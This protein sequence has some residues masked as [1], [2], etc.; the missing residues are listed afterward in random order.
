[1]S[2]PGVF[3]LRAEGDRPGGEVVDVA[4][5]LAVRQRWSYRVPEALR[6]VAVP[7]ARVAVPFRGRPMAGVVL[8][9]G[10]PPPGMKLASVLGALDELPIFDPPLLAFL[11]EAADYY[12]H[13]LG[14]VLR[15]AAPPLPTDALRTLR[16]GGLLGDHRVKGAKARTRLA[17]YVRRSEAATD[18]ALAELR[19]GPHQQTLLAAL[20]DAGELAVET[21][22][23]AVKGAIASLRKRGLVTVTEREVSLDRFFSG[24]VERDEDRVP[25]AEQATAIGAITGALEAGGRKSFLL[26]GVTG[27]GKT[28]VYLQ[29]IRAALA[30]GRGALV[31]VPEIALTPQLV[32]RFRARFGDAI[33]VLHSAL[34]DGERA[35]FWRALRR[36]TVKIAIGARSAVFAPVPSLGLVV[37]DEEHDGSYKQEEGFRY[38]ARDLALLRAHRAGAVAVLGSATPS[39]ESYDHAQKGTH[40]LLTMTSRPLE[41]PLPAVEI[42]D[43]GRVGAGPSGERLLSLTL[44]RA[45]EETLERGG[46]AILFLNRRGFAPSMRCSACGEVEGCPRCSVALVAHLRQRVLRCH[47]CDYATRISEAC[48]HCGE[49]SLEAIGVGTE[50]LEATLEQAFPS[51]RIARLDRDVAQHGGLVEVLDQ[52]RRGAIDILVGTQMVT[53]GHDLPGVT[54]VG[55]ILADQSLYFPD[56]RAAERTFQLLSQVAGRAGRADRPGRVVIQ[57]FQPKHFAVLAARDHDYHRFVAQELEERKDPPYPPTARMVAVRVDAE[58]RALAE[59]TAAMLAAIAQARPEVERGLV[60]ITG[61]APAPIE[62]IRN[63]FRQRLFLRA[64][65]RKPLRAVAQALV[66][67]IDEGLGAARATV[68]VDPVSML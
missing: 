59:R 55:V 33:A 32:G 53:K 25:T 52:A 35:A 21:L 6:D 4:L 61:P 64:A 40:Q 39:L 65:A 37:V 5:P 31:L 58:D 36:G 29:S 14:E 60:E 3:A 13:P 43:L 63:R 49:P 68:D 54:L 16:R 34:S 22:D 48:S 11:E 66:A 67:R 23:P 45:L 27:S 51:A 17:R 57:T 56:F 20:R 24:P 7:G 12:L 41:R 44:H 50:R 10:S 30:L 9:P 47:S 19:L 18:E 8:G 46:Q 1:V 28:E 26:L 15:A 62:K 2:E 38:H 42:V